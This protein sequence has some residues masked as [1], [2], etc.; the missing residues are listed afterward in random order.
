MNNVAGDNVAASVSNMKVFE[1]ARDEIVSGAR[2][3]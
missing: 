3:A 1:A 2:S